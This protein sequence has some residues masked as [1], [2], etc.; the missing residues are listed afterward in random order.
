M[1][2]NDLRRWTAIICALFVY[3]PSLQAQSTAV[4]RRSGARCSAYCVGVWGTAGGVIATVSTAA[5]MGLSPAIVEPSHLSGMVTG[6]LSA[7][8]HGTRIVMAWDTRSSSISELGGYGMPLWWYR[9]K[10]AEGR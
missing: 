8:D 6:G 2:R 1:I 10:V 5:R 3:A 4:L 9:A 7:T